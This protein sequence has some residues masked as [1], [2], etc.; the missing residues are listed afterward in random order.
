MVWAIAM[1]SLQAVF[2]QIQDS[3]KLAGNNLEQTGTEPCPL[4][5]VPEQPITARDSKALGSDRG[6]QFYRLCLEYA[7]TK[8]QADLP[9]QALL[10]LNRAMSADLSGE[11]D[12]LSEYPVPYQAVAWMLRARP[13]RRG[14]FFG[15]PRRHWQH[16][17]TRMSGPR[18]EVRMWRAWACWFLAKKIRPDLPDDPNQKIDFPGRELYLLKADIGLLLWH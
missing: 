7:Q 5:P 14:V 15:N 18:S 1:T 12:V 11:E 3:R 16:Y 2:L 8:W 10:Q 6:V 4:L 13:D 17:A 9:A